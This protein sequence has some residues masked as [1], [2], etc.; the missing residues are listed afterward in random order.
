MKKLKIYLDTSAVSYLDQQDAPD[1]MHDTLML[2]D[3]IKAGKYDVV[4]SDVTMRE[5]ERCSESK[6]STL[7]DYLSQIKY[8][9]VIADENI[10]A[11]AEKFIDFGIL[12]QKSF[13]DCQHIAAAIVTGCDII[14]SWN[15]KHIVNVDTVAGVKAVTAM[16][17][18]NDLLIFTPSYLIG[19][20][21]N[22]T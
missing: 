21:T 22:D 6:L 10:V 14:I 4:L 15:F 5:L 16:T 19:G 11:V 18:Y 17:G 8:E 20:K 2:W 7:F 13:D 1:K 12:K 9:T 3:D